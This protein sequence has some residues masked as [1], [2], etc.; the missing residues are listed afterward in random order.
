MYV[1]CIV[2][3]I[4][5]TRVRR[6]CLVIPNLTVNTATEGELSPSTVT[7]Y[8]PK[9]IASDSPSSFSTAARSSRRFSHTR[10]NRA[11]STCG[12]LSGHTLEAAPCV[13]QALFAAETCRPTAAALEEASGLQVRLFKAPSTGAS[14]I[15][16]SCA[17]GEKRLQCAIF[18]PICSPWRAA[19]SCVAS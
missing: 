9:N 13:L 12:D 19:S 15:F 17:G 2:A 18:A 10:T 3:P 7:L 8:H 6:L 11:H 14:A 16:E 1:T 5:M 4:I